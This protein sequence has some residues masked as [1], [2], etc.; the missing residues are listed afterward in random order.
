MTESS[1]PAAPDAHEPDAMRPAPIPENETRIDTRS[2]AE[3]VGEQGEVAEP[4]HPDAAVWRA[5]TP[6][7]VDAIHALVIA[8]DRVDHPTW[9]TPREDIEE[10]FELA[11]IDPERDTRLGFAADGALIAAAAIRVH[12]SQEEHVYVYCT[13]TVHPDWRRRGIG[14]EVLRWE[15]G[16]ARA[17]LAG[18]DRAVPGAV[19]LYAHEPDAGARVLG[20]RQG[21]VEERWFTTMLRD[22]AAPI[23][24]VETDLRI[25]PF[26]P[27]WW[28]PARVARN[29]AFRDHWGSLQTPPDS[30]ARFVGSSHFRDDLSRIVVDGDRVVAFALAAVHEEDWEVQ[31]YTSAYIGLV[32]VV[33]DH[34]GRGL[35]PAVITAMLRAARDAGLEKV[36]LDVDTESP[37]GANSLYGRLGFD[38]T[39][40]EVAMVARF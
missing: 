2:L 29:D 18:I 19:F 9:L 35:A 24:D 39:D 28:E 25:E 7:D 31:G 20:A 23:A 22:L 13:G 30:W 4:R 14:T 36:N 27:H 34:R 26:G 32:G 8:S 15:V 6:A 5:A 10:I 37:T 17:L 16:S 38:P 11:H 12:P 21:M 33:R 3:R 40:R 1:I